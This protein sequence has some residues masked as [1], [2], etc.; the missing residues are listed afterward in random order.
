MEI[1]SNEQLMTVHCCK[2]TV[3]DWRLIRGNRIMLNIINTS[4]VDVVLPPR[5]LVAF[6]K[7]KVVGETTLRAKPLNPVKTLYF[8]K[9]YYE[10]CDM[11][12]IKDTGDEEG[13]SFGHGHEIRLR[14][15][16]KVNFRITYSEILKPPNGELYSVDAVVFFLQHFKNDYKEYLSLALAQRVPIIAHR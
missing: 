13:F 12:D 5:T 16:A 14:K 9:H 6:A 2:V 7:V 1:W 8:L 10:T 15:K 3:D 4:D 11:T